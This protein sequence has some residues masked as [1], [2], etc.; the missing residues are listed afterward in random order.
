MDVGGGVGLCGSLSV[1]SGYGRIE[2]IIVACG[3]SSI[4][5]FSSERPEIFDIIVMAV[6]HTL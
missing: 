2:E 6:L 5:D 3:Y 4:L 1:A